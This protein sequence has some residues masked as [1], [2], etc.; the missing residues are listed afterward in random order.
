MRKEERKMGER[1][2]CTGRRER[3]PVRPLLLLLP[4][5]L[6]S[7]LSILRIRIL[8]VGHGRAL[9]SDWGGGDSP[10][11]LCARVCPCARESVRPLSVSPYQ[12]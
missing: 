4:L 11:L 6:L 8:L 9:A 3:G 1:K 7:V 12:E 2:I 5:L 10:F